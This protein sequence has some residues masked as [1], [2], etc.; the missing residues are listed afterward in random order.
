MSSVTAL[1]GATSDGMITI[2]DAGLMGMI[3]LRGDLASPEMAKAVK[4]AT[5]AAMPALYIIWR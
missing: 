3:T 1:N 2:S 4:A 5:G